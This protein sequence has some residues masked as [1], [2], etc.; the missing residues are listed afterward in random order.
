[1]I[2]GTSHTTLSGEYRIVVK[3]NDTIKHDTGW[4]KNLI[5]NSGLNR[6]GTANS[7][8]TPRLIAYCKLGTGTSTP[9][10]N[11]TALDN[12]IAVKGFFSNSGSGNQGATT[13]AGRIQYLYKFDYGEVVGTISEVGVGW[14]LG[15]GNLFSRT[16]VQP[17]PITI[18]ANEFLE[19]YYRLDFIPILTDTSGTANIAGTNYNFTIRRTGV[20]NYAPIENTN[21]LSGRSSILAAYSGFSLVP[22][23]NEVTAIPLGYSSEYSTAAYINDSYYLDTTL[24]IYGSTMNN[25]NG[26]VYWMGIRS[27]NAPQYYLGAYQIRLN[28]PL[29]KLF[30]QTLSLTIRNSWARA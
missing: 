8:D 24:T 2:L 16:L 7:G 1:M 5:L 18:T 9:N 22:I 29:T 4:F 13:Y 6:I 19:V 3:Q 30:Y 26:F 20:N 28:T 25:I 17:A 11:Q 27:L 12:Q 15:V 21:Y 23:T 10:V 14:D